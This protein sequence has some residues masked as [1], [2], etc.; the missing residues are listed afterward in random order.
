MS[1][2]QTAS[3]VTA[4]SEHF[5]DFQTAI[6]LKIKYGNNIKDQDTKKQLK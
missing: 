5:I 2:V 1:T 4:D 3:I 6:G